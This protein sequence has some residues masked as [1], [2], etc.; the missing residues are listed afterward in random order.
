MS[1]VGGYIHRGEGEIPVPTWFDTGLAGIGRA[2]AGGGCAGREV[3]G[4]SPARR[5]CAARAHHSV[6]AGALYAGLGSMKVRVCTTSTCLLKAVRSG[7]SAAE[8]LVGR[9]SPTVAH[10]RPCGY[11]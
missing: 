11:E 4:A 1:C 3:R 6:C 9:E 5:V 10:I 8:Q 2:G 7:A